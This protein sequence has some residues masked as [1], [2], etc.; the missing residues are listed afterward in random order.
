VLLLLALA[1]F[2]QLDFRTPT[3]VEAVLPVEGGALSADGAR[4]EVPPGA[5]AEATPL[6]LC[7]VREPPTGALSPVWEVRP[8]GLR[9]GAPAT[10]TLDHTGEDARAALVVPGPDGAATPAYGAS[11]AGGRIAGPLADLGRAWV[12]DEGRIDVPYEAESPAD[13]L[14]VVDGSCS[15]QDDLERFT[16]DL[17]ALRPALDVT[18]FDYHVGVV[19]A[20]AEGAG[21]GQLQTVADYRWFDRGTPM[22][23][24]AE[25]TAVPDS[26][27][28]QGLG[29]AWL[30]LGAQAEGY[31]AGFLRDEGPLDV[32]VVSDEGD[33]TPA[34][35]VGARAFA[36]WLVAL[37]ADSA[38]SARF[39]A[40]VDPASGERYERV[41]EETGGLSADLTNPAA[42]AELLSAVVADLGVAWMRLDP[43]AIPETIELWRVDGA[44][45][46]QVGVIGAFREG[47]PPKASFDYD[48]DT[49]RLTVTDPELLDL[50]PG[51]LRV[52]Y[53][54]EPVVGDPEP[55]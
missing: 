28:E 27:V 26:V 19:A 18:G 40:L 53:E 47:T 54:P 3:C 41:A 44:E 23:V 35:L 38:D 14:L 49:A 9:L 25:L 33:A 50:A 4:L 15:M 13:I 46:E 16:D 11:S 30:A 8:V 32:I 48:A 22:A 51:V 1:C 55:G 42:G 10:L 37:R 5:M 31:N 52:V 39:H 2:R 17:L 20:V 6:A 24:L 36:P 34:A 29:A 7:L 43:P 21:A 45:P 12:S